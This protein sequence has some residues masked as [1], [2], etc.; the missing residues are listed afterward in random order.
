MTNGIFDEQDEIRNENTAH[1]GDIFGRQ[2]RPVRVEIHS[3]EAID[4]EHWANKIKGYL[5]HQPCS[6]NHFP[7]TK[8]VVA[9]TIYPDANND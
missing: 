1:Q 6:V 3:E 4:R 5:N 7:T 9:F 8:E 2:L